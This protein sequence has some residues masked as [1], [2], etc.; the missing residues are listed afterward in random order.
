MSG[1]GVT[2]GG[3]KQHMLHVGIAESGKLAALKGRHR[4]ALL[5]YREALRLAGAAGAPHVFGRHYLHCI[6]ESLE[7]LG[8]YDSVI[9]MANAAAAATAQVGDTP[10]H[11]RD[12]AMLLERVAVAEVKAG[13]AA[14]ARDTLARV[15]E[16]AGPGGQP[17]SAAL[18]DWLRRGLAVNAGR[19]A[20]LQRRHRYWVVRA[21]AVD[22]T[23]A[24]DAPH[25][26][27]EPF[28]GR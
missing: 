13:A 23:R 12:R 16:L 11:R 10:F 18:L 26:S 17:L 14:S 1:V 19:L 20:D 4:E 6:L 21:D 7:H 3:S 25:L 9:E 24:I 2:P 15:L 22:A 27:K 5:R 8:E 28:H